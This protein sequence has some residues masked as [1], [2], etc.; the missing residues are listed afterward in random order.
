MSQQ[1][2]SH[3]MS[4]QDKRTVAMLNGLIDRIQSGDIKSGGVDGYT[5]VVS[6]DFEISSRLFK[7]NMEFFGNPFSGNWAGDN[8]ERNT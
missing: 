6:L 3:K 7:L 8:N 5:A 4:A 1:D 2:D